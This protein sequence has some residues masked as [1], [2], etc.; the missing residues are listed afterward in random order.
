[1]IAVHIANRAKYLLIIPLNS[2]KTIYLAP[3]ESSRP[4]EYFEIS[5]NEK[6]EKLL[7]ANLV[8]IR[9]VSTEEPLVK[10]PEM[11]PKKKPRK[12]PKKS[13]KSDTKSKKGSK[14]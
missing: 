8:T 6:V 4:L 13:K 14:K 5:E 11:R 10:E 9:K 7:K 1:M 3:G 2:G 12:K